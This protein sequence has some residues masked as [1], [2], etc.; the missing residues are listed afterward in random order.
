[1]QVR[2]NQKI[3]FTVNNP[4]TEEPLTD[5]GEPQPIPDQSHGLWLE[6]GEDFVLARSPAIL[7][8]TLCIVL[9]SVFGLVWAV[10]RLVVSG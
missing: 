2:V 9:L 6:D 10:T 7:K 8:I 5:M 3:N 4:G 1:M